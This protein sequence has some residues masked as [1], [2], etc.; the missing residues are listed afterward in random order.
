M[1][2]LHSVVQFLDSLLEPKRYRDQSINGLQIESK[3]REIQKVVVAVD[4]GLSVIQEAVKQQADLLIVHHGLFWGSMQPLTGAL[5]QKVRLLMEHGCS[6]YASHLPLDGNMEVGNGVEIARF[7][8]LEKITPFC[9]YEGR[10]VG[11]AGSA[12]KELNCSSIS[13]FFA[14][15]PGASLPFYQLA[16]GDSERIARI[17]IVTGSGAFALPVAAAE[18][19]DFFI[20]GEPKQE[21]YHMAEELRMNALFIGHYASET[22]GVRAVGERI[23]KTLELEVSFV[24][25][26]TGI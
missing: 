14:S 8:G 25:I 24:D 7:L 26:P 2:Q 12:P 3:N 20:S 23:K 11:A 6:L 10:T 16:F 18:G 9:E 21:V 19:Y 5:G 13:E 15:I 1:G 17:A 4:A 22:F